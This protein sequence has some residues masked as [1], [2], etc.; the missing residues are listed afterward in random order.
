M[1]VRTLLREVHGGLCCV[2]RAP[3]LL[4]NGWTIRKTLERT[5]LGRGR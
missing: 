5:G 1:S 4:R 2:G 3:L